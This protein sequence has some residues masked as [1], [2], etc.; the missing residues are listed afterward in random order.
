MRSAFA[1]VIA[2]VLLPRSA[3]AQDAASAAAFLKM[4]I[5]QLAD[6]DFEAA[7]FSLDTAVRRYQAMPA[8]GEPLVRA[9]VHLGAAYV[10]LGH[11]EAAKGKFREAL[12]RDPHLR[13]RAEEFAPNVIKVFDAQLMKM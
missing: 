12:E 10:G 9:Y 13:L 5:D 3:P 7:V 8:A 1:F 4:G 2:V 6:G 11:A